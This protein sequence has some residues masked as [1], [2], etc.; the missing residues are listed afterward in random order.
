MKLRVRL[1]PS[2]P[3]NYQM[4]KRVFVIWVHVRYYLT[5]EEAEADLKG[6]LK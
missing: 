3:Y 4:Q 2:G 6:L 5:K 1:N